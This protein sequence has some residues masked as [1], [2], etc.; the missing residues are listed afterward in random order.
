MGPMH[1][2]QTWPLG[3][4][5]GVS[6]LGFWLPWLAPDPVGLQLNG[7][8]LSDWV[9]LSPD[10]LYRAYPVSRLMFVGVPACLA[11]GFGLALGRARCGRTW[12]DWAGQPGT[13]IL[14]AGLLAG[15]FTALPYFPHALVGWRESEWQ[16]PWWMAVAALGIGLAGVIAPPWLGRLG[17]IGLA[18][19]GAHLTFWSWWLTRPLAEALLGSA[20]TGI[21]W[22]LCL[23]GWAAV[24][25][26]G[27]FDLGRA[28]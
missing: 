6:L 14:A 23:V 22:V 20:P 24:L 19:G 3:V 11:V 8:E 13:W 12:R 9:M 25:V 7:F 17:L 4:A 10:V 2:Y 15:F 5:L 18:L 16:Q 27:L 28:K 1:R 21:G 26:V